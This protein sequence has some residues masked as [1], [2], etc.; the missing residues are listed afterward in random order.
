MKL[1]PIVI[2][3]LLFVNVPLCFIH[4][5][6]ALDFIEQ[7]AVIVV[8]FLPELVQILFEVLRKFAQKIGEAVGL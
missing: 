4:E 3:S 2:Q 6:S 7:P 8:A 1:L 5:V